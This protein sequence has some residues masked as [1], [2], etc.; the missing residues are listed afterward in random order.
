MTRRDALIRVIDALHAEIAALKANDV[1]GLETAT[2]EKLAGIEQIAALGTGPAGDEIRE[3]ADEANRL[4]ETC[5][6]YVN[7]MAA[8]VR[9]RLQILTGDAGHGFRPTLVQAYA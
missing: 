4:N 9:R 7:L 5:R 2:Q 1:V 6:I 8:N 3:L